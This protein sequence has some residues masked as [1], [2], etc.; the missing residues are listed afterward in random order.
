MAEK[1]MTLISFVASDV[2]SNEKSL[3]FLGAPYKWLEH[4]FPVFLFTKH[5]L[6]QMCESDLLC[7]EC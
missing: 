1:T 3:Q 7:T 4:E 2:I 5:A 6:K